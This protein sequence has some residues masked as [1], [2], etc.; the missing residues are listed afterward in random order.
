[1]HLLVAQIEETVRKAHIFARFGGRTNIKRQR[2]LTRAQNRNILHAHF[3]F[4]RRNFRVDGFRVAFDHRARDG[5]HA[6]LVQILEHFIIVQ[7]DLRHTVL[8]AQ[9]DKCHAAVVANGIHPAGKGDG[10]V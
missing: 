3:E 10:F 7:H 5:N 2:A 1:M 9:I 6:L 8:V 4:A